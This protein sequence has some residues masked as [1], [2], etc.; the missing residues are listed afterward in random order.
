VG[1]V[2]VLA[3]VG[4]GALRYLKV[5]NAENQVAS[6]QVQITGLREQI[7]KYNKVEQEHALILNLE[8]I[9]NPLVADEV[10]WPGVIGSLAN[11]RQAVALSAV[12]PPAPFR[13]QLPLRR[14]PVHR[15]YR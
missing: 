15:H 8:A 6:L 12:S 1:I 5:R 4:L 3:M 13:E 7:P 10:Y 9:S 11:P 14:W 2:L